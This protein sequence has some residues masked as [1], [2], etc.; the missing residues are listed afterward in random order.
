MAMVPARRDLLS[1]ALCAAELNEAFDLDHT[2]SLVWAEL[3]ANVYR[4]RD[5]VPCATLR[6]LGR[7]AGDARDEV[8]VGAARALGAF[9]D[10]DP[11]RVETALLPLACDPSRR[12]RAAAAETLG[13]LLRAIGDVSDLIERWQWHPDRAAE[14]LSR[15]RRCLA[16]VQAQ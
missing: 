1:A 15:A 7:L 5:L 8:R 14:V 9:T 4:L 2:P 13:L 16:S 12:V 10:S 6:L 3:F 11:D